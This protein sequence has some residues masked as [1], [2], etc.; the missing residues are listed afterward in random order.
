MEK[1]KEFVFKITFVKNDIF[2]NVCNWLD[3]KSTMYQKRISMKLVV[4]VKNISNASSHKKLLLIRGFRI[5][6]CGQVKGN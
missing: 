2:E 5:I 6:N 3:D 4:D 1:L